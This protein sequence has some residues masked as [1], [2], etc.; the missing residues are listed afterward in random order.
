MVIV[1]VST[2]VKRVR[3]RDIMILNCAVRT[4]LSSGMRALQRFLGSPSISFALL[5]QSNVCISLDVESQSD[6]YVPHNG[7]DDAD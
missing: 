7:S 6:K 1:G 4:G 3:V 5:V 2:V